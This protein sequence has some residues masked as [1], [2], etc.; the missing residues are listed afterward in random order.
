MEL[1]KV[2][3]KKEKKPYEDMFLFLDWLIWLLFIQFI[4]KY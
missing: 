2:V 1:Y 4:H 3:Q